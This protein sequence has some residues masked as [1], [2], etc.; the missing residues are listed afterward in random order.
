MLFQD[1]NCVSPW[2]AEDVTETLSLFPEPVLPI[3]TPGSKQATPSQKPFVYFLDILATYFLSPALYSCS[4][5]KSF[6]PLLLCW[7]EKR[8]TFPPRWWPFGGGW[9]L[10]LVGAWPGLTPRQASLCGRRRSPRTC[11][12]GCPFV[13][14][15]PTCRVTSPSWKSA[16]LFR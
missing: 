6:I 7:R 10:M 15:A 2:W 13:L 12:H 16:L 4:P 1:S 5:N 3:P 8:L 9:F 11:G 14:P